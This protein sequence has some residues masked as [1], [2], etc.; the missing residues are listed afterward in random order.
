[1][2]KLLLTAAVLFVA[3]NVN[4]APVTSGGAFIMYN[5]ASS[6]SQPST[7]TLDLNG[8]VP[9]SQGVMN[10][11]ATISGWVDQVAG[12]WGV[13]STTK[14]S[15]AKWT[16]TAGQLL[17]TPGSYALDTTTNTFVA[18]SGVAA[19]D[20]MMN[21]TVGANQVAGAINFAWGASTGIRVV[22]VWN[23][24]GDG[25]LTA[26]A[27]PGMENGP[28]PTFQ[29]SFGLTAPNLISS[30][31]EPASMLLIGSGLAGLLGLSRRRK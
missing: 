21:I 9:G 25:S 24:N 3:A 17:L 7:L 22:E 6:N 19:Y 12:T 10:T 23:V 8:T 2:K 11:D 18:G 1:M 15:G 5:G 29:A 20:G 27:A 14:F 26:A 30:V 31:P 16:A 4:A 13:S 28:F